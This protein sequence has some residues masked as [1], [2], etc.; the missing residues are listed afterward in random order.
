MRSKGN[1]VTE[2]DGQDDGRDEEVVEMGCISME[3]GSGFS[4]EEPA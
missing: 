3:R 1:V 4:N 2:E